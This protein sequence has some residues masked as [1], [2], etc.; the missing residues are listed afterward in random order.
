[1][2]KFHHN[3]FIL[4]N[5]KPNFFRISLVFFLR[6]KRRETLAKR[7]KESQRKLSTKRQRAGIQLEQRLYLGFSAVPKCRRNA[8]E[9]RKASQNGRLGQRGSGITSCPVCSHAPLLQC[10]SGE[11]KA[12][13]LFFA[14]FGYF[15]LLFLLEK[16]DRK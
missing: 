4:L 8:P 13:R 10:F 12:R 3:F 5:F 1:M 7:R 14:L 11:R 9:T 16:K 15:L 6:K 2:F